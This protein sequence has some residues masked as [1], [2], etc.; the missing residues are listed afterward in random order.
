METPSGPVEGERDLGKILNVLIIVVILVG[1]GLIGYVAYSNSTAHKA[2]TPATI[3]AGDKVTM[4]YIG[5][6]PDGRVFD[7]SLYSVATNNGTYPKSLTFSVRTNTTYKP[8]DMTAGNYGSGGTIKGFALGVIGLQNGTHAFI[9]V[10][11][12]EGYAVNPSFV[13]TLNVV[14]NISSIETMTEL[15]FESQFGQAPIL[16]HVYSHFFWHWNVIV[17]D[18]TAGTV[19]LK[20]TPTVGQVVYPFG[21]PSLTPSTGWPVAVIGYDGSAN[22]GNGLITLRHDIGPEDVYNLKG[23]D[24][25]GKT[26]ILT[27]YNATAGTLTIGLNDTSSGYNSELT[28]RRLIFEVTILKVE[29]A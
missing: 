14:E 8:F 22:G 15:E 7:T 9:D 21:N 13:R 6:L 27:G 2:P 24:I 12:D 3:K 28:G 10:A 23:T 19:V 17:V 1:A 29:T 16:N 4:N 26:F 20:N 25:D 18:D 11:S 5:R